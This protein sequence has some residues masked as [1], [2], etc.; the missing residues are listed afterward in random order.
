M[1]PRYFALGFLIECRAEWCDGID[2]QPVFLYANWKR[3][4]IC[5]NAFLMSTMGVNTTD[6]YC[7]YLA[8]TIWLERD[9]NY[10][11]CYEAG[12]NG[13][14]SKT[15]IKTCAILSAV[16]FNT[17]PICF[18]CFPRVDAVLTVSHF[19][20]VMGVST[21]VKFHQNILPPIQSDMQ[22]RNVQYMRLSK[23]WIQDQKGLRA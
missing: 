17:W 10:C 11:C 21:G 7:E 5:G 20:N 9:R 16:S 19:I 13:D 1:H 8:C 18:D 2:C 12:W 3:S 22:Y 23:Y 4:C 6:L 15:L 14:V